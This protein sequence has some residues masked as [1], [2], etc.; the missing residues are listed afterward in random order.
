MV[1]A[2]FIFRQ[3]IG[4]L[5]SE[6]SFSGIFNLSKQFKPIPSTMKLAATL[7]Q[8][9]AQLREFRNMTVRD[10]AKASRFELRRLEDIEA[11]ME[12]WFS[13]TERQL[14]AKALSVEPALLQEVEKR[15]KPGGEETELPADEVLRINKA[16]LS[17]ARDLECPSCG[18]SLKCSV[19]EGLDINEEPIRFAKAFCLQCPFVLR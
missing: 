5:Y 15:S 4:L 12:T 9:L 11:G 7:A 14:L 1:S 13:S 16:I 10:L 3:G 17:G 18:G 6:T 8:R 2:A 19:Q